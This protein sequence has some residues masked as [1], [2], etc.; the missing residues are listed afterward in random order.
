MSGGKT[1]IRHDRPRMAARDLA[2]YMAA[3]EV[4][5]RTIVRNS[6]FEPLLRVAHHDE[7]RAVGP[8]LSPTATPT[9]P[10]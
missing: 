5:K 8:S 9:C 10:G 2:D 1:H 6:K 3:S 7:A 4:S